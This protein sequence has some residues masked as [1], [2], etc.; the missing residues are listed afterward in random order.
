[1][2]SK[3]LQTK[4]ERW[5][6]K[7][8]NLRSSIDNFSRFVTALASMPQN[9][10]PP[11]LSAWFDH[12]HDQASLKAVQVLC[13]CF[14]ALCSIRF[15]VLS[16]ALKVHDCLCACALGAK[17]F[18]FMMTTMLAWLGLVMPSTTLQTFQN[19]C[20]GGPSP[21]GVQVLSNA[22]GLY[23]WP[24]LAQ[25][26]AMQV[27]SMTLAD[28]GD[29]SRR[30]Q[31][32]VAALNELERFHGGEALMQTSHYLTQ[33]RGHLAHLLRLSDVTPGMLHNLAAVSDFA[34]GWG[35]LDLQASR[36][37]ALVSIEAARFGR[38]K[39]DCNLFRL[40]RGIL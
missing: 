36:L 5:E 27:D 16:A 22:T 13:H 37:Q 32:V 17:S 15:Y 19:Y 26:S 10:P 9:G 3:L 34:Y 11:D 29:S 23:D 18:S 14:R 4:Q 8:R 31:G 40:T 38:Q 39:S 6:A 24:V 30:V 35:L 28:P 20:C 2:Y 1:M 21:I 12:L 33:I 25:L 7:K